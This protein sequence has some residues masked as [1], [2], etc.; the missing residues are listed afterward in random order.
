MCQFHNFLPWYALQNYMITGFK[1]YLKLYDKILNSENFSQIY[2]LF[3][4]Q[5]YISELI[6][7]SCQLPY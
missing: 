5:F 2:V 1:K 7:L 6:P 3:L 4:L